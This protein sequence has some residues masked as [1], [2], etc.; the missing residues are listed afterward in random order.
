VERL[1]ATKEN[2]QG[3][4]GKREPGWAEF[5]PI[6]FPCYLSAREGG[7]QWKNCSGFLYGCQTQTAFAENRSAIC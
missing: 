2:L 6:W 5:P 4:N 7:C 3:T 1:S